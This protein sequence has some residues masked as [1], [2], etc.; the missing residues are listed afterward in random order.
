MGKKPNASRLKV[1]HRNKNDSDEEDKLAQ[2]QEEAARLNCEVWEIEEV[3]RK[4]GEV[5]ID[6]SDE[7]EQK[8]PPKKKN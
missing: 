8:E 6:S 7:E 4:L 2:I 3:K 5:A 1:N